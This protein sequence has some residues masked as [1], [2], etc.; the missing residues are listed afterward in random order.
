MKNPNAYSF[1]SD[2]VTLWNNIK[3][4][5]EIPT[6]SVPTNKAFAAQPSCIQ[7]FWTLRSR[8]ILSA[9]LLLHISLHIIIIIWVRGSTLLYNYKIPEATIIIELIFVFPIAFDRMCVIS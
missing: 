8:V 1:Y 3:E 7:L 2:D 4:K 5:K 6:N 9:S